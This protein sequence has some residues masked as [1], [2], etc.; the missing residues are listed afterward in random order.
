MRCH[1]LGRAATSRRQGTI[2]VGERGIDPAGL[3][4]AQE[5]EPFHLNEEWR[6][7]TGSGTCLALIAYGEGIGTTRRQ[8]HL[9]GRS[10]P[11][12]HTQYV[13]LEKLLMSVPHALLALLRDG[14]K[15]GLRLQ[16]EF[17]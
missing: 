6:E 12:I 13:D 14:P 17:E 1:D 9:R 2:L 16:N 3:G 5:I 11:G 7:R 8:L 15:Y 10:I 4:V